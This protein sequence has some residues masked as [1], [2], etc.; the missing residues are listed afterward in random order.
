MNREKIIDWLLSGD[1][2]I[3]WQVKQDLLKESK[4]SIQA[5]R[6]KISTEGWGQ[7]LLSFQDED[8]KWAGQLYNGKWISTTYSLLLLKDFGMLPNTKTQHAC[9]QLFC[10]GLYNDEEI[11]YSGKQQLR[12]NGVTGLVLGLLCY[13]EFNDKRIHNIAEYLIRSQNADGSWFFDDKEGAEKYCFEN[14]MIILKGLNEYLKK[15]PGSNQQLDSAVRKG[16]GFLLKHHLFQHQLTKMP[17]NNNW[18]KI[19]FPYYWFYDVLVALDYFREMDIKDKRLEAA[20]EVIKK[21]QK[22][23]GTWNSERKHSGKTFFEM[24]QL[25][26]PSR[27]NTLRCMRVI[28]WWDLHSRA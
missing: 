6:N 20:I 21:K 7:K 15:Y 27:W 2:S 9:T 5:E 18:L 1:P 26:K 22:K 28:E 19:S 4:K 8:G 12:D 3:R 11:R 25:G 24:E 23:E 10:G 17:I 14:T 16:Q 13:F